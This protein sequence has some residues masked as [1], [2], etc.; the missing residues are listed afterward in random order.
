L[1]SNYEFDCDTKD[2]ICDE[3]SLY[4]KACLAKKGKDC[5]V[6]LDKTKDDVCALILK[7]KTYFGNDDD[8]QD[9]AGAKV[10]DDEDD[11]D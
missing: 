1:A 7:D 2:P 10:D 4:K 5:D 6:V 9:D 3:L 11:D 8:D